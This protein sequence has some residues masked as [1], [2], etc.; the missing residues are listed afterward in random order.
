MW[1]VRIG[2]RPT[3]VA[4]FLVLC[5][6]GLG[7]ESNRPFDRADEPFLAHRNSPNQG[8]ADGLQ[9][10]SPT[11]TT[12][13]LSTGSS[14]PACP[15]T[16]CYNPSSS[17]PWTE[18][19]QDELCQCDCYPPSQGTRAG[20]WDGKTR[21]WNKLIP[22]YPSQT[23]IVNNNNT[24]SSFTWCI[25]ACTATVGKDRREAAESSIDARQ[26]EEYWFCHGVNWIEG[27]MCELVGTITAS[28]YSPGT[29]YWDGN[30]APWLTG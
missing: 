3:L 6:I 18:V 10:L 20:L 22:L 24:L 5:I 8:R 12:P 13:P 2:I 9:Y 21:C 4:A 27:D 19:D 28:A 16:A 1:R 30:F 11:G 7:G 15:S 23:Q 26:G 25:G 14:S 29:N 17:V